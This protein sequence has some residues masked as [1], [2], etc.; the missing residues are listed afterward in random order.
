MPD[1]ILTTDE[2]GNLVMLPS[3]ETHLRHAAPHGGNQPDAASILG[4]L[5]TNMSHIAMALAETTKT[6]EL[7]ILKLGE[8]ADNEANNR[9]LIEKIG[10]ELR[11][12]QQDQGITE[13]LTE[14]LDVL[15]SQ[16]PEGRQEEREAHV[17]HDHYDITD[18]KWCSMFLINDGPDDVYM[19]L[20]D[21]DFPSTPIKKGE[22]PTFDFTKKG[23]IYKVR[24]TCDEGETADVRIFAIA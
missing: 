21:R 13:L 24:L 15:K 7:L 18:I 5:S 23:G 14:T 22:M 2:N 4:N 17:T 6:N 3:Q 9:K 12:L 10:G 19:G 11:T 8:L 16:I 1:W 20:N